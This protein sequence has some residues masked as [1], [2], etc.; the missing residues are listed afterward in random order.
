M[1][2][3]M[4]EVATTCSTVLA[5]SCPPGH[6]AVAHAVPGAGRTVVSSRVSSADAAPAT[7]G[8][9]HSLARSVSDLLL[10]LIGLLAVGFPSGP[11]PEGDI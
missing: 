2:A 6:T 10:V 3:V 5:A 7:A 9:N 4:I 11:S 1:V 8:Q